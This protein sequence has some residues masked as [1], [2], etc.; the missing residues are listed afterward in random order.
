MEVDIEAAPP[1]PVPGAQSETGMPKKRP[2]ISPTQPS[3]APRLA[4]V[5][6]A[7]D[8][9]R[10]SGGSGSEGGSAKAAVK[11][12]GGSRAKQ[13]KLSPTQQRQRD[14]EK[15][16][17]MIEILTDSGAEVLARKILADKSQNVQ[18]LTERP[19][20]LLQACK[21][22]AL[23]LGWISKIC[24]DEGEEGERAGDQRETP[25][26]EEKVKRG[27]TTCP[28]DPQWSPYLQFG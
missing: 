23:A 16:T 13:Q 1:M 17:A 12:S 25:G 9:P 26:K 10:K 24:P 4:S 14:R 18:K 3:P 22:A 2:P 15:L 7:A 21:Q 5:A 11:G 27:E 28:Q 6:G 20:A 19:E 8:G